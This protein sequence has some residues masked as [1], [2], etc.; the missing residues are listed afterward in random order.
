MRDTKALLLRIQLMRAD[1]VVKAA[2]DS[3]L[4]PSKSSRQE[5][6]VQHAGPSYSEA[7]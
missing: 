6:R 4:G 1:F 2:S 3:N 7:M 5:A